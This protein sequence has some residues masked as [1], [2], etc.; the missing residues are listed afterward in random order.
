VDNYRKKITVLWDVTSCLYMD[1][2]G[3]NKAVAS[4]SRIKAVYFSET[5]EA[6]YYTAS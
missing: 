2:S 1:A 4:I 5:L 6:I 3:Y